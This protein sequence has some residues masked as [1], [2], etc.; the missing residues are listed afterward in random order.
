[1]G[2]EDKMCGKLDSIVLPQYIRDTNET[3][4]SNFTTLL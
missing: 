2:N 1:M 3:L 4:E